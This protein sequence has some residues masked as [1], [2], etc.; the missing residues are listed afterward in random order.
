MTSAL[1]PSKETC[2]GTLER[3]RMLARFAGSNRRKATLE[4]ALWD[5]GNWAGFASGSNS[6]SRKRVD[7]VC[8]TVRG[9]PPDLFQPCWKA[10]QSVIPTFRGQESAERTTPAGCTADAQH[11]RGVK[12]STRPRQADAPA[13][14]VARD[15]TAEC[16]RWWDGAA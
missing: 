10:A 3:M 11:A 8:L 13:N 14:R 7:D 15:A 2:K 4:V 5:R 1:L 6:P 12:P 16:D 9:N